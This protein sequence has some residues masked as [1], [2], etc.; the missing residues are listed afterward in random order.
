MR[1]AGRINKVPV[2]NSS[3]LPV[4]NFHRENWDDR[5]ETCLTVMFEH[6]LESL[7]NDQGDVNETGK[8]VIGLD[9]QNV[10]HAFLYI[11]LP[12]L[13]DH[14]GKYLISRFL[15]DVNPRQQLSFS[16][17]ELWYSLLQ[18]RTSSL[19]PLLCMLAWRDELSQFPDSWSR[20]TKALGTRVC[21]LELNS[22]KIANI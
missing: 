14:E 22:K 8:K 10:H 3:N 9:W 21:L 11:S 4:K 7:S 12:S 15:E 5:G 6:S 18:S 1:N 19:R 16:F 20:G 13:H 2:Y 17:P